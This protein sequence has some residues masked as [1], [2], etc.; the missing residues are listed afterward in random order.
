MA[1]RPK[2]TEFDIDFNAELP[3]QDFFPVWQLAKSWRCSPEHVIRLVESG[4]LP[5][6]LDLRNKA[7][8]K[9]MIRVPRKSVVKFLT[10]R[11]DMAAIAE[12]NPYPKARKFP[13]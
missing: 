5:V 12:A 1:E 3:P 11:K 6:G 10:R 2:Q 9:T 7:S 4:E 8:S 13:A